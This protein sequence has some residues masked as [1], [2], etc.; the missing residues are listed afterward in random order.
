[1]RFRPRLVA[2][3]AIILI[4]G[5]LFSSLPTLGQAPYPSQAIKLIVPFPAGGL[6]DTV[7][8]IVARRLQE[9]FSVAVIVEN[10][11]GASG[12]IAAN[13]LAA[14]QSDGYT[15][16]VTDGGILSINPHFYTNLS[17]KTQDLIPVALIARAPQFLA[18]LPKMHLKSMQEFVDYAKANPGKLNYGSAGIG[19][20]HHLSMEAMKAALGLQMTHIPYKGTAESVGALLGGHVDV[21]FSSYPSLSGFIDANQV[22]LLATNGAQRDAQAPDVPPV[23]D[24]VAGYDFAPMI[25]IFA[26]TGTSSAIIEKIAAEVAGIMQ[27][28]DA[29]RLLRVSGIEP[30]GAGPV[31][32][33]RALKGEVARVARAVEAAG[34]K[35]Q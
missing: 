17:Y 16:M 28:P 34:I 12:S 23:A 22:K 24:I 7:A 5:S 14:S 2:M 15:L 30:V 4:T 21:V 9:R 1:M 3:S 11:A 20:T 27:E 26:R 6:P 29:I 25:G 8:R 19:S 18:V 35:S 33:D 13:A 32:F 31:E 10:R